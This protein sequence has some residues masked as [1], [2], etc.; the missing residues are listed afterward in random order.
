MRFQMA[1]Q[2][3]SESIE[4]GGASPRKDFTLFGSRL[5]A[6]IGIATTL[7]V[8]LSILLSKVPTLIDSA[9]QAGLAIEGVLKPKIDSTPP[10]PSI[11]S[12]RVQ[13]SGTSSLSSVTSDPGPKPDGNCHLIMSADSTVAPPVFKRS[14]ECD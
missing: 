6:Y 13:S 8:A 12:P 10:G 3:T 9:Q 2:N 11:G 7:V 5:A 14:W 1:D 4:G